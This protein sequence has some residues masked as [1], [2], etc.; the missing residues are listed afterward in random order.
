[1]VGRLT[2]VLALLAAASPAASQTTPREIVETADISGLFASPDGRWIAY[3]IDKPS[4]A[5]NR[6]DV[7]W[8]L[9]AADG[10]S[11]PR[12]L[13]RL[14]TAMWD[15]AGVIIAGEAKWA[16]DSRTLVVRALV[17]GRVGLWASATDGSG[18]RP[19][20]DGDG[21]IE[22]F[23]FRADG[24]LVTREG[25]S[26]A[27]IAR[28][29]EAERETGIL[30][31]GATDLA[32]PLYHGAL[33]NG[34]PAT[35]RFSGDWFDRAPLLAAAPRHFF[36]YDVG[37]SEPVAADAAGQ[38]LLETQ[39]H[40][41][42]L[43]PTDLPVALRTALEARGMCAAKGQ[44]AP[45][46][47]RLSWWVRKSD[48]SAV[49]ALH[50]ADFDQT[51]FVWS[52]RKARLARLAASDGQ[53][54]GGRTHFLPCAVVQAAVFC[55][56]ATPKIT[57]RLVRFGEG[58]SKTV[59]S[60]PN[61]DPDSEGLLAETIAWQVSGSRASGV[62]IR[63]KI[64]GRLPLFVT[65]YRCAGY[66]RGGVGDEWPLR[67]LAANGIAALCINSVPSGA[68]GEARYE[69]GM[70]AVRA[71]IDLLSKRGIVDPERVG[72]GGLSFGSE[73][74]TWTL[75]HSDLL[76][77]ASIA[78]VQLE[79]SYY[80]FNSR[81]GRET[82]IENVREVWK[83]GSPDE[84]PDGWKRLSAALDTSN[85]HA[86]LLMQLPEHEARLSLELFS[87]L[88]TARLAEMHIFPY[89]AHI[90]AEPRQKLAAYQRNLDWFRYWLQ[91]AVDPD[92]SKAGQYQRWS[93][94]EPKK[95]DVSTARTQRSTSAISSKRK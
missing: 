23:A 25:P 79:P 55:V 12:S 17:D 94:L 69:Q 51:L 89:A 2:L 77:A 3:R 59:I 43:L 63:P 61:P 83:V 72:M 37:A 42:L 50:D 11:P 71:A 34:R 67:A 32:Q 90:K 64:P 56:E 33:I 28:A 39:P 5:T 92:P 76:K 58:G 14:G 88:A 15:D 29:E 10:R 30:V 44:C 52:G 8:Y 27:T 75:R 18:F 36:R 9:V 65:Y 84:S 41:A 86:P 74:T 49:V 82:F 22:A 95:E 7:D 46:E 57:P 35:Q 47:Q 40:P 21:D 81:P 70:E 19:V 66:L 62:L 4:T 6:I 73:V 13:G 31:D 54:S 78:S 68:V 48:G 26:R 20:A 45:G 16:P 87:K 38:A 85:I 1:M 24:A 60:S 53:L 93:L 91:G 80:W